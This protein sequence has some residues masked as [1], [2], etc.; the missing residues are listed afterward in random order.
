MGWYGKTWL[1]QSLG[2]TVRRLCME[3]VG[4]ETD[5]ARGGTSKDVATLLRWCTLIW[6]EIYEARYECP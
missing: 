5:P 4:L 6:K 1:E 3:N 2:N